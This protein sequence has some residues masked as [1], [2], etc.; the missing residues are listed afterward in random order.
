MDLEHTMLREINQAHKDKY[1]TFSL[2]SLDLMYMCVY[3]YMC[4]CV[5]MYRHIKAD[6]RLCGKM[7][8]NE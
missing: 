1:Q 4:L 8:W 6:T 2:E 7:K 3:V 5:S